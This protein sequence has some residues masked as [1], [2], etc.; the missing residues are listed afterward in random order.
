M[1][2]F[3]T[4][5][6]NL[7]ADTARI[8]QVIG[9]ALEGGVLRKEDEEKYAKILP[10]LNDSDE[11]AQHKIDTIAADLQRKLGLYQQN[12]GSSGGGGDI[13]SLLMGAQ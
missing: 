6:Q 8:K 11:V 5:A 1:N 2:P 9:K 7:Q 12:L 3:D 4:G 13:T 10:T